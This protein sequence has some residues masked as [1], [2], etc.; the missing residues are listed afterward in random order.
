M[1]SKTLALVTLSSGAMESQSLEHA[2][3]ENQEGDS[4]AVPTSDMEEM[5]GDDADQKSKREGSN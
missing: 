4:W 5:P 3:E 2:E 1:A